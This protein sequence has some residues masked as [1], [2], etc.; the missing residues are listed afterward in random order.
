MGIGGDSENIGSM[1]KL[2]TNLSLVNRTLGRVI[3]ALQD[4]DNLQKSAMSVGVR[5]SVAM[6]RMGDTIKNHPGGM[7][8]SF[9]SALSLMQA[10]LF[11]HSKGMIAVIQQAKVTGQDAQR[12]ISGFATLSSKTGMSNKS[13][14]ILG[15]EMISLSQTWGI[16]TTAL[17][18]SLEKHAETIGRLAAVGG[19]PA[20]ISKDMSEILARVG[21]KH[22]DTLGKLAEKFT[23][24]DDFQDVVSL[25][26]Q[27][28][29]RSDIVNRMQTEGFTRAGAKEA[30]DAILKSYDEQVVGNNK[31]SAIINAMAKARGHDI[32]MISRWRAMQESWDTG[33]N[34]IQ[35]GIKDTNVNY[36]ESIGTMLQEL[37]LPIQTM[38]IPAAQVMAKVLKSLRLEGGGFWASTIKLLIRAVTIMTVMTA[39]SRL[40]MIFAQITALK[41][42]GVL[43]LILGAALLGASYYQEGNEQ[44][45]KIADED[46][47]DRKARQQLSIEKNKSHQR[48][49]TGALIAASMTNVNQ[50]LA[51]NLSQNENLERIAF[52]VEKYGNEA[53]NATH[54]AKVGGALNPGGN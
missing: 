26:R 38:L 27:T 35:Q 19:D 20:E 40:T 4:I 45:K 37:A 23:F 32:G 11:N 16:Q 8:A 17:I 44:D 10:G 52:G 14:G 54:E 6:T 3:S 2:S 1:I 53:M 48:F 22:S 33:S 5:S 12:L 21:T 49:I 13:M 39:L 28:G 9:E 47:R 18:K 24:K 25:M 15:L 50:G 31:S 43:G 42:G 36:S 7:K 46:R 29:G 30:L 51:I 41:S 34:L